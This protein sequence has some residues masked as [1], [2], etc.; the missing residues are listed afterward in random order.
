MESQEKNA[1]DYNL[2]DEEFLRKVEDYKIGRSLKISE[3]VNDIVAANFTY[4]QL[5]TFAAEQLCREWELTEELSKSSARVEKVC[6]LALEKDINFDELQRIH[7]ESI[8]R[9]ICAGASLQKTLHGKNAVSQR[10]DQVL[11]PGWVAHCE[12]ALSGGL[13]I[14]CLDDLLNAPGYD[15]RITRIGERTLKDWAK[16]S[17]IEFKAGRPKKKRA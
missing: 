12:R 7:R 17:G 10:E 6:K 16:E 1:N 8:E 13:Q 14:R 2:S 5:V 3:Y 9:S 11:K 4:D 15:P